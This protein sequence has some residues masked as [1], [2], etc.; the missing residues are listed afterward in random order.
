LILLH[1]LLLLEL[2]PMFLQQK[3]LH[4]LQRGS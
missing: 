4:H 3:L 2:E 1:L